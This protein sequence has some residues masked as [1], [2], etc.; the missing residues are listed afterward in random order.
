MW[1][2]IDKSSGGP[3]AEIAQQKAGVSRGSWL[4]GEEVESGSE[5]KC[6]VL[7]LPR[8]RKEVPVMY[9]M[10]MQHGLFFGEWRNN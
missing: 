3:R 5:S 4:E 1:M 10:K 7:E 6:H 2:N 8:A 9:F